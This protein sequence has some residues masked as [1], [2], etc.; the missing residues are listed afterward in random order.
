MDLGDLRVLLAVVDE[1]GVRAAARVLGVSPA[2]VSRAIDRLERSVGAQLVTSA[3]GRALRQTDAGSALLGEARVAFAHLG[4]GVLMARHSV[5]EGS[6]IIG[7]PPL[8]PVVEL[9]RLLDRAEHVLS[10]TGIALQRISWRDG[11]GGISLATGAIDVAVALIPGPT[12]RLR[13][14]AVEP[15]PRV[16]VLSKTH[17]LAGR[18]H[19]T[20]ADLDGDR[21]VLGATLS[22][23]AARLW[24]LDPQSDGRPRRCWRREGSVSGMLTAI[25]RGRG[26]STM[27]ALTPLMWLR[28]DLCWPALDAE[29]AWLGFTCGPHTP[30]AVI[31]ALSAMAARCQ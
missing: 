19:V 21:A 29:P 15:L 7:L 17:R 9:H 23:S 30:D 26:F 12:A 14:I 5:H 16:A 24:G 3:P 11:F 1:G 25:A 10:A 2:G 8:P 22:T 27:P 6:V 13:E 4:R 31:D 20:A 28:S 18:R